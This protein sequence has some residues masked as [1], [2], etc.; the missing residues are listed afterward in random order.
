LN[1]ILKNFFKL[2]WLTLILTSYEVLSQ[3]LS[4]SLNLVGESKLC[5]ENSIP[6]IDITLSSNFQIDLR[7]EKLE[8]S[9][10]GATTLAPF[11]MTI[12]NQVKFNLATNT[13]EVLRIDDDTT[14]N[15]PS[16]LLQEGVSNLTVSFTVVGDID[17]SNNSA[18]VSVTYIEP[19]T[20]II[21]SEPTGFIFCE[22]ETVIFNAGG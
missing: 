7:G 2:I 10:S 17:L 9:I 20:P 22:N 14:E 13:T 12:P 18:S 1:K 5:S 15:F 4:I 11:E 6:S 3:D 19:N 8:F 16:V 21:T